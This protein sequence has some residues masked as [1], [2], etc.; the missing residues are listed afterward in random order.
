MRLLT[1]KPF[2]VNIMLMS[3]HAKDIAKLV[4]DEG[5]KIVTTGAGSPGIYMDAWKKAGI[6][7]IPCSTFSCFSKKNG[8]NGC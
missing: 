2:G 3:P 5:V 1:D 7:V 6:I 8:K 4:I